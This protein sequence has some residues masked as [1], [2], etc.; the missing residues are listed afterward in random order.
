[1]CPMRRARWRL[2]AGRRRSISVVDKGGNAV[3]VTYTLNNWF[4]ADVMAPGTGIVLNDEMDDFTSKPG[5]ANMFGLVQGTANAIA[6]G[7]TPLSSMS[8]TIVSRDGRLVMVV[9]SPGGS[10]I[11]TITAEAIINVIDHSMTVQEAIDAPRIH[12]Q[13]TP[14]VVEVERGALS[15]DTRALLVQRGYAFKDRG[16]WGVAEAILAGG[17][18]IGP[19]GGFG[20]DGFLPLNARPEHGA[21]LFGAHD[22]RG[23]A[24]A[25]VAADAAVP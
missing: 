5:V 7:K 6:P 20:E 8:P 24:G 23:G 14:D 10:R 13:G 4:G 25:A 15:P 1:M 9:G 12:M 2:R 17:P 18:A 19:A 11:I 16:Y 3:S 21:N 22:V